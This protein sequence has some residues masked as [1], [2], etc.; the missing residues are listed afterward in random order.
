MCAD[1]RLPSY[2]VTWCAGQVAGLVLCSACFA[3]AAVH[4][5]PSCRDIPLFACTVDFVIL[6]ERQKE[7]KQKPP[8]RPSGEYGTRP[9][10]RNS[11]A[12]SVG[13]ACLTCLGNPCSRRR[14]GTCRRHTVTLRIGQA[15]RSPVSQAAAQPRGSQPTASHHLG[16]ALLQCVRLVQLLECRVQAGTWYNQVLGRAANQG[17]SAMYSVTPPHPKSA[18]AWE[19]ASPTPPTLCLLLLQPALSVSGLLSPGSR[20]GS[21]S[22]SSHAFPPSF[23]S[24]IALFNRPARPHCQPF[25]LASLCPLLAD[26]QRSS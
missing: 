3:G 12:K 7:P 14:L 20:S 6:P 10:H 18:G 4:R 25:R 9:V 22:F 5:T 17:R 8:C 16:A 23:P 1:G 21:W 2:A 11:Q 13:S 19:V 24:T 15:G 26:S